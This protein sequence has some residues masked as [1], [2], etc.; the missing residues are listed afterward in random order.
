[1]APRSARSP[2]RVSA[3]GCAAAAAILAIDPKAKLI[4]SS[5]YS[6]DAV[7]S[8]YRSYGF[9]AVLPKPYS[10][11]QLRTVVARLVDATGA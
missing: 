9:R 4:V 5:G 7:M 10:A 3:G 1:M 11:E 2:G 6:E 8:D